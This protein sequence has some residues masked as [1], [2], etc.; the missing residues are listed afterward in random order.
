ML[1][2]DVRAHIGRGWPGL[3][4]QE[5]GCPTQPLFHSPLLL[6]VLVWGA[7][8]LDPSFHAHQSFNFFFPVRRKRTS[9]TVTSDKVSGTRQGL[10]I[11][12]PITFIGSCYVL[13]FVVFVVV[14]GFSFRSYISL[15]CRLQISLE[16]LRVIPAE[17]RLTVYCRC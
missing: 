14:G 5:G 6:V 8:T 16:A 13:G 9:L 3:S 2:P 1:A 12:P 10:L 15:R 7:H 4:C 17:T 11:R